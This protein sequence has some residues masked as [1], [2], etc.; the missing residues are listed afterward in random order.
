M[1]KVHQKKY[2][3]DSY[4]VKGLASNR[5]AL[6][7]MQ[8]GRSCLEAIWSVRTSKK[9]YRD[10]GDL[11]PLGAFEDSSGCHPEILLRTGQELRI[12]LEAI[13]L[14]R[15]YRIWQCWDYDSNSECSE[16]FDGVMLSAYSADIQ[17]QDPSITFRRSFPAVLSPG[18]WI[19]ENIRR[20][21]LSSSSSS[22]NDA[23]QKLPLTTV[24]FLRRQ[25]I[26]V[27]GNEMASARKWRHK[28]TS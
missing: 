16:S 14:W 28:Q 21:A 23:F 27:M 24:S 15:M 17:S 12:S 8:F 25:F 5:R 4:L 22:R 26:L 1:L 3:T 18:N 9:S 7:I 11:K 20:A 19:E 13:P 6:K 2:Q 10:S